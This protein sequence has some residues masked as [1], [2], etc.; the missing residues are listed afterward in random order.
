M[1]KWGISA[2]A[3]CLVL[4]LFGCGGGG[5]RGD[6][7]ITRASE[8]KLDPDATILAAREVGGYVVPLSTAEGLNAELQRVRS[9]FPETVN[10]HARPFYDPHELH[11]A[12]DEAAPWLAV[13]KAGRLNTE[14]KAI[15]ELLKT[16]GAQS[17]QYLSDEGD[18]V[19]FSVTFDT[20][21]RAHRAAGLFIGQSDALRIASIVEPKRLLADTDIQY[22]VTNDTPP[23]TRMTFTQGEAETV[24]EKITGG[25]WKKKPAL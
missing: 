22:E 19:W 11:F 1:K 24:F 2:T 25:V 10:I 5:S 18:Q 9:A 7:V 13:W 16:F 20:Y 21:L 17:V 14:V 12:L 23:I 8:A 15:D 3:L 4:F 6:S